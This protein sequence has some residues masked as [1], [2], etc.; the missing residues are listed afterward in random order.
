MRLDSVFHLF[1]KSACPL[2]Q[3]PTATEFCL[4]CQKELEQQQFCDPAQF[5]Q[6]QPSVFAWGDYGGALKRAIA[7]FKYC[8]RADLARPLGRQVAQ[9]WLAAPVRRDLA[10]PTI[11]PIP[12]HVG[13]HQQRGYNQAEL[14]AQ[15]FCH[16]TGC[17][18]QPNGLQ[19]AQATEALFQLSAAQR[20]QTLKHA[21]IL[22]KDFQRRLPTA[23]V[24]L[25]DD[26][27]TSGA[28]VR[29]AMQTL[30]RHGVRVKGVIVLAKAMPWK[31]KE[32][33]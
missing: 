28:T 13:K 20:E 7:Q 8:D 33:Q 21:F 16:L 32:R 30:R 17:R 23:P 1:L 27:Y 24:L 6:E 25:L 11:V 10:K 14:L 12:L 15:E 18:L 19:R 3:R 9:A 26:I 5:W 4:G 29:S 22:G 2:C 31:T